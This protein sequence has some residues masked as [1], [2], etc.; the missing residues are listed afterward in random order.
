MNFKNPFR[1]QRDY[2]NAGAFIMDGMGTLARGWLAMKDYAFAPD[3][4]RAPLEG[5]TA[6]D[7][8]PIL[9][10]EGGMGMTN[11]VEALN[12]IKIRRPKGARKDRWGR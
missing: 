1:M 12:P 8:G 4:N 6:V 2:A 5:L 11:A 9:W 3:A 10:G 7:I